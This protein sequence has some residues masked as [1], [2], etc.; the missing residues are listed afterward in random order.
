MNIFV[1]PSW[2]PSEVNPLSGIFIKEQLEAIADL[3]PDLRIILSLWGHDDSLFSLR[4]PKSWTRLLRWRFRGRESEFSQCNGVEQICSKRFTWSDRLPFGGHRQLIRVNRRNFQLAQDRWGPVDLIH[5]H[6]SYPAGY[7]ALV[8]AQQ[9]GVPYVLTE[10]MGPFPFLSLMRTGRPIDEIEHAFAG[11]AISM[12]VSPALAESVASFGYS[13]PIVVPNMV[14]ERHFSPGRPRKD[15][16]VFFTLCAVSEKKGIGHLLEAIALWN[17]PA[18]KFEFV[19]GGD[20]P[21]R[22]QYEAQASSLGLADR[23]RWLG[24]IS[25]EQAPEL[26]RQCHVFVMPSWHESFGIVYVEAMACGKPVIA[27]RCGGPESIVHERNGLLVDVGDVS[28]LANAMRTMAAHWDRYD[29]DLIR[30]DFE[31]RFSRQAVVG[32]LRLVYIDA[33]GRPG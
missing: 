15:K 19:I 9:Y 29:A 2:Y 12:A 30:Q 26:F 14:D 10:H 3:A 17:P 21:Q 7:I 11:A 27:T 13:K 25:R 16:M 4:Q 33:C 6:V 8:L 20:G 5:A 28:G 32:Q 1:V 23:V 31:A 18:E 24:A 22:A